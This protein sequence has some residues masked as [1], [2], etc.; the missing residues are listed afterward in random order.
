[1][2]D[3]APQLRWRTSHPFE[4]SDHV[5]REVEAI[6]RAAVREAT[7]RLPPHALVRV[8]FRRVR[9][10]VLEVQSG[11]ASAELSNERALVNT[12]VVPDQHHRAA[13]VAQQVLQELD[14]LHVA[15]VAV[16]PLVVQPDASAR[17]AHRDA[18]DHRDAVVSL[19]VVQERRLPARCPAAR[20][21]R[22][23]HEA[24]F[25]YEDE[26]GPQVQSPLFTRGQRVLVQ[27]AIASS[28]RS[29]ARRSGF[30]GLQ[31]LRASRRPT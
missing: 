21:R 23:E 26:V 6:P 13:Q 28:S 20:D 31:P 4:F 1:M 14:G 29:R 18:R 12:Q 9:G 11:H 8:E 19:P 30:C 24:R 25:V 15:D 3:A 2:L 10:Q 22:R 17:R 16:M 5:E 7:L 27:R